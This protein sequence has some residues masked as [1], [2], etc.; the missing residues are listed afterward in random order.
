MLDH[1]FDLTKQSNWQTLIRLN[2]VLELAVACVLGHPVTM[3]NSTEAM[4]HVSKILS[5]CAIFK[6]AEPET[7]HYAVTQTVVERFQ[8]CMPL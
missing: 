6:R 5:F 1:L 2:V 4:S 7:C 3:R 8:S